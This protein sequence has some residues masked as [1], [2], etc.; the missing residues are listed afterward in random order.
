LVGLVTRDQEETIEYLQS[1][2][3]V[4]RELVAKALGAKRI[5]FTE[6]QRRRL[7]EFGR[8]LGWR[9]LVKYC[10][11]ATP[12]TIYAWHRR[13]IAKKYDS[14]A[15]R[16]GR[17]IGRPPISP[18]TRRLVIR[19]ASENRLWGYRRIRDVAKS[20]GH[21]LCKTTVAS[22]LAEAGIEPAPERNGM[23]WA[24]F[25]KIHWH[26][27]ASC[28]FFDVEVLTMRGYVRFQ[29]F[30]VMRIETRE[31]HIAGISSNINGPW[32]RQMARNL[33][34]VDDGFL[35][36]MRYLIHDR[37]P[38]FTKEFRNLLGGSG[39]E[40]MKL[41][42]KS[43]NLNAHAER[44]VRTA[45][46]T[47]SQYI[48][49]GEKHLPYVLAETMKHYSEE[50]HHQGLGGKLIRPVVANDNVDCDGQIER[51]ERL[52]GLLNFYHRTAA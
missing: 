8:K 10:G 4:L 13:L 14:S 23:S 49:F 6:R 38:L 42:A 40:C 17:P 39:V 45:R 24:E 52:G 5:R 28:D 15:Q 34:D 47:L 48:F 44:F 31:V 37:D 27:I 22:I 11:V 29:V 35:G 32:M 1:E 3:K 19:L 33:T 41:P 50:R 25:M 12:G 7:A 18:E 16:K 2:N 9:R 30:F 21:V 43:P 36:G 26:A 20:L 46:E 51:K